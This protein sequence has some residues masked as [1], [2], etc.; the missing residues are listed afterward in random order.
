MPVK[1]I[2]TNPSPDT[3]TSLFLF[4]YKHLGCSSSAMQWSRDSVND[5]VSLKCGCDYCIKF[6]QHGEAA[7]TIALVST[8]DQSRYLPKESFTSTS[9]EEVQI[10]SGNA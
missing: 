5:I 1:I 8:D 9:R 10:I 4:S 7:K 2:A 6:P 3:E